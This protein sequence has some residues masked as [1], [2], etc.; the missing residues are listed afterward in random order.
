MKCPNCKIKLENYVFDRGYDSP[1]PNCCYE[2]S[3]QE[4]QKGME[5]EDCLSVREGEINCEEF[6]PDY[7]CQDCHADCILAQS[8]IDDFDY[9]Q[10][11]EGNFGYDD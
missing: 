6:D 4:M 10:D 1:C 8:V 3:L 7:H 2:Y 11:E 9:V 5:L